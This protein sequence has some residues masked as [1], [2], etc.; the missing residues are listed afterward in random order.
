[1]QRRS[2]LGL[3]SPRTGCGITRQE[4]RHSCLQS[5]SPV[6][7]FDLGTQQSLPSLQN[8]NEYHSFG[9]SVANGY[10]RLISTKKEQL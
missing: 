1:M 3:G 7:L 4:G 10:L 2:L 9:A 8:E 5:G 6:A